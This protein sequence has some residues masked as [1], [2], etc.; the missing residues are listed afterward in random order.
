MIMYNPEFEKELNDILVKFDNEKIKLSI[1]EDMAYR[2]LCD[3]SMNPPR[4]EDS[5][6]LHDI[7]SLIL[8]EVIIREKL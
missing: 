3:F 6:K 7:C 1:I 2:Y 5:H 4:D 8:K